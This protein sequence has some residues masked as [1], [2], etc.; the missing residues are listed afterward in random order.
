M[1]IGMKILKFMNVV[2]HRIKI[3]DV[4]Y[5]RRVELWRGSKNAS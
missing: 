5:V 2:L 4:K 1:Q 3:T